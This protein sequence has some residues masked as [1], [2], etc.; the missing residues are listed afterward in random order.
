MRESLIGQ[1]KLRMEALH[2]TDPGRIGPY[3]L[4]GR[5]GAGGMGRC[6]SASRPV[7]AGWR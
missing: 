6:S 7:A 3:K 5:L 2:D 1:E 4:E